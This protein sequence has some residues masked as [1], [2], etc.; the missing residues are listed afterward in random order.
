P[1]LSS[2]TRA[3][4][5]RQDP[6][7]AW[8]TDYA[9]IKRRTR[10]KQTK[11]CCLSCDCRCEE[12]GRNGL[13]KYPKKCC[14]TTNKTTTAKISSSRRLY[15]LWRERIPSFLLVKSIPSLFGAKKRGTITPRSEKKRLRKA[16][17]RLFFSKKSEAF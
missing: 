1:F 10:L 5:R 15:A 3:A 16:H 12:A 8:R 9:Y 4:N 7:N 2:T 14:R 17:R 6:G 11:S 13:K